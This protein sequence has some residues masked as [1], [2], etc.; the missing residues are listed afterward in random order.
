[1]KKRDN[2]ASLSR[3]GSSEVAIDSSREEPVAEGSL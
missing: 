1:M 2:V 3:I